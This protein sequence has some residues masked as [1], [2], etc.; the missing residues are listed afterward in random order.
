MQ[1]GGARVFRGV[2]MPQCCAACTAEG[3]GGGGLP[4]HFIFPPKKKIVATFSYRVGVAHY[5]RKYTIDLWADMQQ[6]KKI[7]GGAIAS[8]NP[9]GYSY[10]F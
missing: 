3:V 4:P 6:K 1:T 8:P 10:K 5:H 9:A 7:G 2:E